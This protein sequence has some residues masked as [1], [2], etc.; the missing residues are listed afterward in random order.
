M[1]SEIFLYFPREK[2]SWEREKDRERE[3]RPEVHLSEGML[4]GSPGEQTSSECQM[5]MLTFLGS[6]YQFGTPYA[7]L[8][9][10]LVPF[11]VT[12]YDA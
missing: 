2:P 10:R 9:W 8:R 1:G 7:D 4:G 5:F 11:C 3:V 6:I 12:K